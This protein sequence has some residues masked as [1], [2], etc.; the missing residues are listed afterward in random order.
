MVDLI[1]I[2][3]RYKILVLSGFIFWTYQQLTA[4][5][6]NKQSKVTSIVIDGVANP[7]NKKSQYLNQKELPLLRIKA[8]ESKTGKQEIDDS[9]FTIANKLTNHSKKEEV[10]ID[11]TIDYTSIAVEYF[12]YALEIDA[13]IYNAVVINGNTFKKGDILGSYHSQDGTLFI[14][15]LIDISYE[16]ISVSIGSSILEKTL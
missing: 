5:S 10:I 9:L 1:K 6:L 4:L 15:K 13:F 14:A 11:D 3:K 2:I 8:I 12:K 7:Q 16:K